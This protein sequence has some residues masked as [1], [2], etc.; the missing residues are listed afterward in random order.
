MSIEDNSRR[1]KDK[2]IRGLMDQVAKYKG[3]CIELEQRQAEIAIG[4]KNAAAQLSQGSSDGSL[5]GVELDAVSKFV[6]GLIPAD[7]A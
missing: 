3:R 7:D 2:Y 6:F 5:S 4:A 1:A